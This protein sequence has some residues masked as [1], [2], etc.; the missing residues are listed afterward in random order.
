MSIIYHRQQNASLLDPDP[1]IQLEMSLDLLDDDNRLVLLPASAYAKYPPDQLRVW[2]QFQG[3][4]GVPT[5]ELVEWLKKEIGDQTAIEIGAGHGD[6]GYHLG[7]RQTDSYTQQRDPEIV[8]WYKKMNM[9]Q[10]DPRPDVFEIGAEQA[11]Q[12]LKP[13]VVIGSW[14]TRRFM[15]GIDKAGE[16]QAYAHGPVEEKILRGC[17]KY[18]HI[19]NEGTHGGKTLLQLPHKVYHFDWLVSRAADQGKNC[20]YVWENEWRKAKETESSPILAIESLEGL[21]LGP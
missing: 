7:I 4:Y 20:I 21:S 19:G 17:K 12:R 10:T 13:D 15:R 11:V 9:P 14:I 8:A 16:A 1:L 18:I 3:R 6:L 5:L 2:C